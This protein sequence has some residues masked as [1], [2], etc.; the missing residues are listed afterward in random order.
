MDNLLQCWRAF[1]KASFIEGMDVHKSL[2][3]GRGLNDVQGEVPLPQEKLP[4]G[5]SFSE[6]QFDTLRMQLY[7]I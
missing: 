7:A 4:G 2:L 1:S 3:G 6:M 5:R